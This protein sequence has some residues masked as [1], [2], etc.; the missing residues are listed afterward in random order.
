MAKRETPPASG[1]RSEKFH[2]PYAVRY[3][4][5]AM[6][7]DGIPAKT[8]MEDPEFRSACERIGKAPTASILARIKRSPEYREIVERRTAFRREQENEAL[9][10]ALL[11]E[12][13]VA[14]NT[15]ESIKIALLQTISE[16]TGL[17]SLT[18]EEEDK[19]KAIRSLS[20]SVTVLSNGAK[21]RT[22]HDLKNK[23]AQAVASKKKLK[24]EMEQL[25]LKQENEIRR[26]TEKNTSV[27]EPERVADELAD[28][29]GVRKK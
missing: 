16:L 8:I 11:R 29:L 7:Q 1:S 10:A 14:E 21:D 12:A 20:Q 25:K 15:A 28:I 2:L 3:R 13:G 22:I 27:A 5:C 18:E 9:T 26:I 19:I 24:A 4:I 17:S 6:L 23:L